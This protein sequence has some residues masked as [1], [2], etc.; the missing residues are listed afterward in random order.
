MNIFFY[1]LILIFLYPLVYV[2]LLIRKFRGKED[3]IRFSERF[4]K[5]NI[6]RPDGKL[7]WFNA[8][9][10]GEINSAWSIIKKLN[11]EG[12]YNILITTT[13]MTS[14]EN[15]MEKIKK[16]ELK[17]NKVILHQFVPIDFQLCIARFLK[18]WKP[19][20]L[21]NVESEFWPNLFIMTK[22]ICPI[23]VLNGKM[24]KKSFKFWYRNKKLKES[25][26][27]SIDI[28]LAQ[29]RN[30]YK[31][32]L[33]LGVQNVQFLV[34]AK[35]FAEKSNIDEELF[36]YLFEKTKN[37]K[38]W[39][40][41]CSH[42]GEEEIIVETHKMLKNKYSNLMTML[43]IRHPNRVNEVKNILED[44]KVNYV[45]TSSNED[46][47]E[48]TEFYIYDKIGNLGTFFDLCN[49]VF[50]A[51]SLQKNIGGHTP[52]E[53]IKHNCCI[54]TGPYIENNY[55]LFKELSNI[56]G[57]VVLKDNKPETLFEK[58]DF[59]FEN[60]LEVK[61]LIDNSYRKNIQNVGIFNEIIN[62]IKGKIG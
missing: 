43:I 25:I 13:T 31:R 14:A 2:Y 40:V 55:M 45:I 46:V 16:L 52:A 23:I 54:I 7:I 5:T 44:N 24:S 20:I 29:S 17:N 58:V 57:C 48:S 35:F 56:G 51:G 28:C 32:F 9:S 53:A 19:N 33:M 36:K 47:T 61:G 39:L 37:K 18:H 26:F 62:I 38:L 1:R 42:S 22:K 6:N 59:L 3:K 60:P 34:N 49:I 11:D 4:G 8:V 30:D 10:L 12:E 41:N 50:M 15:V 27:D 21:I